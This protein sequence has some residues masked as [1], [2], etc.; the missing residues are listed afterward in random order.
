MGWPSAFAFVGFVL[1]V[2]WVVVAFCKHVL[3]D[4]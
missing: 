4:K 2:A 1:A 3:G